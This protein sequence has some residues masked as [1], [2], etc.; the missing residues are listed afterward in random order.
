MLT[1]HSIYLQ[2]DDTEPLTTHYFCNPNEPIRNN[3]L[4]RETAYM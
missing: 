1:T 2:H 3:R 4:E